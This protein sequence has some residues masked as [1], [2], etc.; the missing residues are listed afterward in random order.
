MVARDLSN[1][2]SHQYFHLLKIHLF[3]GSC[4][5]LTKEGH[6]V[7]Q[8]APGGMTPREHELT[9]SPP[10]GTP[11]ESGAHSVFVC[12]TLKAGLFH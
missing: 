3:V 9:P 4:M 2:E 7:W 11:E 10:Q 12:M 8:F 1:P 6:L 5:A